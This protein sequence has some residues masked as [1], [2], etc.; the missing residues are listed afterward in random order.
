MESP[1]DAWGVGA[2]YDAC[3]GRWSR[4][5]ARELLGWLDLSPGARWLDAGC[6]TGTV[7]N[8]ILSGAAPAAVL[9]V[10]RSEGFVRHARA[11]ASDP[12]ACFA[13]GDA[14]A[15]P[16][17]DEAF[18]AAVSGLVL[19][20]V[21][22]PARMVAELARCVRPEGTV[23]LYVWDYAGVMELM[24]FF[25][26]AARAV[27]PQAAALD[28]A[29]RFPVCAPQPLAELFGAAGLAPVETRP[30][31]VPTPFRDFDDYWTP[32]LGGQ[33]PAPAPSH[34]SGRRRAP[35]CAS[36]CARH[37][38]PPPTAPSPC[39]RAPGRCA[40]RSGPRREPH[41]PSLVHGE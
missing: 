21:P 17:V 34:R 8:A 5:V 41:P 33:G 1:G 9:G 24:R 3:V 31:D 14:M 18:D 29:V 23:A 32:F 25:W 19:N 28:E 20:F 37:C 10:D 11:Q 2:A 4:L 12:R 39:K 30:I 26:S 27:V 7:T 16:V 15:L 22:A 36:G 35:R 13:V 40:G 38:P 6:G